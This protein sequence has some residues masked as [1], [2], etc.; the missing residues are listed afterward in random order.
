MVKRFANPVFITCFLFCVLVYGKI[1]KISER[2]SFKSLIEKNNLSYLYG[3]INSNP[4]KNQKKDSYTCSILTYESGMAWDESFIFSEC[5]GQLRISIPSKYVESLYPGKLFSLANKENIIE[6][7]ALVKIY[8]KWSQASSSFFVNELEFIGFEK[9]FF[10]LI[11]KLRAKSRLYFKKLM[12]SWGKAG[13]LILALLSGSR[14]YL[15]TALSEGFKNSGLSHLLA[16]SGMHLSF[17]SSF[18]G[19]YSKIFLGK[20]YIFFAKL[21]GVIF[22]VWFAGFSPSLFRSFISLFLVLICELIFCLEIDQFLIL[23]LSFLI[24]I[25]I[26]P[27]DLFEASFLLSYSAL[28][29]ILFFSDLLH[30]FMVFIFPDNLSNSLAASV[31]AQITSS[32]ITFL[33]FGTIT[34]RKAHV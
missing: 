21:F 17:F 6:N 9:S 10:G 26:F 8:G 7:G 14:E 24:H 33:L 29:G 30:R 13:A 34:D 22:F 18:M 15:D 12:Y 5:S 4:Q 11:E 25:M 32:P 2:H 20:K 28:F 3:K 1:I 23:C 31:S 27:C 19:K 16:L